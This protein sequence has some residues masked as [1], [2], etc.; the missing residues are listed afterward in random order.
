VVVVLTRLQTT[1][2]VNVQ[3]LLKGPFT[4]M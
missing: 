4:L 2:D 3:Q 1:R